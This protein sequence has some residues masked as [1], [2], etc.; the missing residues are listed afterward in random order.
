MKLIVLT[1]SGQWHECINKKECYETANAAIIRQN[2][3]LL[4]LF[5]AVG[6]RIFLLAGRRPTT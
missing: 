2:I 6:E 4:A 1:K 5:A 3:V